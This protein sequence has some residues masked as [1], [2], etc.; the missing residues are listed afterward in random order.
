MFSINYTKLLQW[1]MPVWLRKPT[2]TIM[3]MA[4]NYPLRQVYN[5][6][7]DY[8][9]S[10]AKRFTYNYEKCRLQAMLNDK[11][12]PLQRRIAIVD[13]VSFGTI[14][15]YDDGDNKDVNIGTDIYLDDEDTGFD[16]TIQ[17]PS[18]IVT[19]EAELAKL[20]ANMNLYKLYGKNYFIQR[21]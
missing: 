1:L 5:G 19:T 3:V 12:D 9:E 14:W 20:R 2:I 13:F 7:K 4:A 18:T 10:I 21:V 11:F 16:F 8:E 6:F 17:I 15:L